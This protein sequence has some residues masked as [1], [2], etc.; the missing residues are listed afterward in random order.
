MT[1]NQSG[2]VVEA[3]G[4][5]GMGRVRILAVKEVWFFLM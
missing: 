4:C 1:T 5:G 3:L 2:E